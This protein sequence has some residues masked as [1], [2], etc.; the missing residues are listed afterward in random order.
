MNARHIASH[1]R[2]VRCCNRVK[3]IYTLAVIRHYT[4]EKVADKLSR[5]YLSNDYLKLTHYYR[6]YLAGLRDTR[7]ADI[8]RTHVMWML[9]PASGPIRIAYSE[10]TEEMSLLSRKPG[11]LYGGHFWLG[12][13][14]KP[15]GDAY[16]TYAP[17]NNA[18]GTK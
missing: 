13:D 17:I 4:S 6:G 16:T 11:Q 14:G 15:S 5:L 7:D 9:G 10:W 1:N 3:E 2:F 18:E 8:W 12:A